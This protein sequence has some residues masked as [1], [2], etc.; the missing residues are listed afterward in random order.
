MG[1]EEP[2][3]SLGAMLDSLAVY[4]RARV[5][6]VETLGCARSNRDPLAEFSERFVA[7]WLDGELAANRVQK[8]WDLR[9]PEGRTVQVRCLARVER[10]PP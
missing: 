7:A 10:G 8:D 3:G 5:E 6:L 2:D 4:R 1:E 9:D